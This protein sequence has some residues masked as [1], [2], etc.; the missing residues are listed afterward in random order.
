MY[1][2]PE[3]EEDCHLNVSLSHTSLRTISPLQHHGYDG[4]LTD[5]HYK[6]RKSSKSPRSNKTA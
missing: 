1:S 3:N 6:L 5:N 2:E 4:N